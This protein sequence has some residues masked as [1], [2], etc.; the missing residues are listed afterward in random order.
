MGRSRPTRQRRLSITPSASR[1]RAKT[2]PTRDRRRRLKPEPVGLMGCPSDLSRTPVPLVPDERRLQRMALLGRAGHVAFTME[3]FSPNVTAL[4][5][6][7]LGG[8]Q[9]FLRA[10]WVAW[11]AN[12]PG[13]GTG[14]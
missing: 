1:L 8:R 7:K 2:E 3:S 6:A 4:L 13:T 11:C 10:R 14:G 12:A 5:R 9:R